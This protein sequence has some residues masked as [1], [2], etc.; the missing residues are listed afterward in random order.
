MGEKVTLHTITFSPRVEGHIK[1]KASNLFTPEMVDLDLTLS[2]A[3]PGVPSE[4]F[5]L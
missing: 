2:Q 1:A 4:M 3:I 5:S